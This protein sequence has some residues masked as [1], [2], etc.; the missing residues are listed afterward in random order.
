VKEYFRRNP[1]VAGLFLL[2][3]CGIFSK[4]TI[5]DVIAAAK[6]HATS[7]VSISMKGILLCVAFSIIGGI[8]LILGPVG[9]AW[10]RP[11]PGTK[12]LS[13]IG[14]VFVLLICGCSFAFYFWFKSYI[15]SF[16]YA[17]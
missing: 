17:F 4:F 14:W 2:M 1:R 12:K 5:F 8:M 10:V 16:G 13:P 11:V 15:E 6:Q 3:I 7:G 9:S